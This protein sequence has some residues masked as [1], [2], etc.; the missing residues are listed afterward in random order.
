MLY[1]IVCLTPF[2]PVKS[3]KSCDPGAQNQSYVAGVYL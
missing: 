2:Y 3:Q 1:N